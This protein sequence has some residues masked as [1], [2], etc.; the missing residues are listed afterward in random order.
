MIYNTREVKTEKLVWDKHAAADLK[1]DYEEAKNST[2]GTMEY[3]YTHAKHGRF[4]KAN[5][6]KIGQI[7]DKLK[8]SKKASDKKASKQKNR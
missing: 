4:Y 5:N 1:S 7:Q 6:V 3:F 8:N 2:K